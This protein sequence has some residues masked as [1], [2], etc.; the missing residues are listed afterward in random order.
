[1]RKNPPCL[2]FRG[3]TGDEVWRNSL[4]SQSGIACFA[5]NDM[6]T[7]F[8]SIVLVSCVGQSKEMQSD[9]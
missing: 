1:M 9:P 3:A 5:P 2:S 4:C 6:V 8:F 7:T